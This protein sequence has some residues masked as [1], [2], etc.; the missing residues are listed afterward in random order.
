[1]DWPTLLARRPAPLV[2]GILNVTPDSF[3]DGGA[4]FEEDSAVARGLELAAEGA[5]ILD[6]GGES[7]RPSSYGP[8]EGVSPEEE[9]RRTVPV[10]R[11]LARE[12]AVP[13]SIDT[14]KSSVPRATKEAGDTS[15]ND[16]T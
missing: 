15:V 9:I 13:I 4:F 16:V 7:T 3:S 12:I 11:R 1:M 14:R 5:D 10:I 8:A 2:M 6:I